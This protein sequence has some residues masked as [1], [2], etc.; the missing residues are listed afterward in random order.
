MFGVIYLTENLGNGKI[1]IG[2][3]TKNQGHG[4]P[5]YLGSGI[6]IVKSIEKYGRENFKKTILF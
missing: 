6:L 5:E 3:D 2:S 4:D 1:Y